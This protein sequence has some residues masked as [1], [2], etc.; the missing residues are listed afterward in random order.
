MAETAP[1]I[2][3]DAEYM[4]RVELYI[5]EQVLIQLAE[6]VNAVT[7]A[8]KLYGQVFLPPELAAR[9]RQMIGGA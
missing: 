4:E 1:K 2:R 5:T 7:R 3:V 6:V 8:G 9:K